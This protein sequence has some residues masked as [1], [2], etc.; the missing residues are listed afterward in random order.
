MDRALSFIFIC[1]DFR[2][3]IS[4]FPLFGFIFF[5]F[6]GTLLQS[7]NFTIVNYDSKAETGNRK[8]EGRVCTV[9][10][11]LLEKD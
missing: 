6:L 8:E 11:T 3:K 1:W 7:I 10:S 5:I 4:A 9:P 2:N